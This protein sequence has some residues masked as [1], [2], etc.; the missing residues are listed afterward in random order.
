MIRVLVVDDMQPIC[1]RYE[2]LINQE[3]DMEVVGLAF[4]GAEALE[5]VR[6]LEGEGGGGGEP[7][8]TFEDDRCI[9]R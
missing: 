7:V 5:M 2:K 3:E 6:N 9:R 8:W 1:R 4:S